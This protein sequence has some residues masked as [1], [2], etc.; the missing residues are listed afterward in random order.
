MKEAIVLFGHGSREAQWA[1]PL[2][3][4]AD[5]VSRKTDA[6]VRLAYLEL[7]QPSLADAI[8]TLAQEGVTAI[9]VVPVFL[10]VGGHTRHDLPMLVAAA[11][12]RHAG[13]QIELD[14]PI[15]EQPSVIEA[16]AAAIVNK[17]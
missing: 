17:R 1:R 9:R 12:E 15:G 16:I 11:L 3:Q 14:P 13:V 10:G 5:Q 4:L 6:T 8:G 7:M 2:Q